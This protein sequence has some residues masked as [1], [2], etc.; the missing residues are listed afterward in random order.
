MVRYKL[1]SKRARS[2]K[3]RLQPSI[4]LTNVMPIR[5]SFRS[6]PRSP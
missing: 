1:N 3:R 6:S 4:H 5:Y 2:W